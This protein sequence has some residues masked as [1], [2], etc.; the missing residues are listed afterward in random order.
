M[1]HVKIFKGQL[2]RFA[3]W[4]LV[5]KS[6]KVFPPDHI[7]ELEISN[8]TMLMNNTSTA[9]T[10]VEDQTLEHKIFGSRFRIFVLNDK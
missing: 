3:L 7:D 5:P 8:S 2:R 4:E 6:Y 1:N 10:C 9:E